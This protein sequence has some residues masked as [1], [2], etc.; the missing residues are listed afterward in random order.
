MPIFNSPIP[1]QWGGTGAT[2][3]SQARQNLGINDLNAYGRNIIRNPCGQVCQRGTSIA[4]PVADQ[5][6]L[7]GWQPSYN[8]TAAV[9]ISQ[10][11]DVP[12][13][14][15]AGY[16]IPTS[17]KI[18]VT[19]ADT[20][21]ATGDFYALRQRIEGTLWSTIMNGGRLQFWFKSPKSGTHYA[22]LLNAAADRICPLSFTV[23]AA[24]TWQKIELSFEAPNL[25]LGTWS[26][27]EGLGGY[28][29][30]PL[31]AGTTY[32]DGSAVYEEW[33]A[34]TAGN[35]AGGTINLLDSTSNNIFI[36]DVRLVPGNYVD[37][38]PPLKY[39]DELR[40]NQ[41]YFWRSH[42]FVT[43]EQVG[44]RGAG[45]YG[46]GLLYFDMPRNPVQMRSE[47]AGLTAP[48]MTLSDTT[49]ANYQVFQTTGATWVSPSTI[50]IVY[51]D[52]SPTNVEIQIT[53][54]TLN[55]QDGIFRNTSGSWYYE[56]SSEL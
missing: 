8:M 19:T 10:D 28:L 36:T 22:H 18:D 51:R 53:P 15:E 42:T 26:F 44:N 6:T 14:A 25:L 3:A 12:S 38:L 30:I 16:R 47:L 46:Y 4:S 55:Y 56:M 39:E 35:W 54:S 24:N 11:A 29:Q 52:W 43:N 1:I 40:F 17:I 34:Y 31:G 33:A 41:R 45:V 2:T 7:D 13:I 49:A 20:A 5:Y 32:G 21:L 27:T 48:T 37:G 9:T 50:S 23:N